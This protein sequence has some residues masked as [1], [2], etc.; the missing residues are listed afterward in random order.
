MKFALALR[1]AMNVHPAAKALALALTLS[2]GAYSAFW[3]ALLVVDTVETEYASLTVLPGTV[4]IAAK[5]ATGAAGA[6]DGQ[7]K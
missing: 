1:S 5:V 7:V 4:V 3:C 6:P 2:V